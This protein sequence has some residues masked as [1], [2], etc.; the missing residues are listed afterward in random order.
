MTNKV[1]QSLIILEIIN[2][3]MLLNKNDYLILDKVKNIGDAIEKNS[4]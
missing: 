2:N 3:S 4:E 1:N